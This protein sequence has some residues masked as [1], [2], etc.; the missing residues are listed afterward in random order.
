LFILRRQSKMGRGI[1]NRAD[2]IGHVFTPVFD[3]P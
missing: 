3:L 1:S 2:Y